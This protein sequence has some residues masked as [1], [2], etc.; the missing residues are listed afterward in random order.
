MACIPVTRI[1]AALSRAAVDDIQRFQVS[2]WDAA[3]LAAAKQMA[4]HTVFSEDM[5][6][7]QNHDGVTVVNPFNDV[8]A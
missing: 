1:D 2:Y 6:D 4:C 5:N 8:S 3:I 7:G